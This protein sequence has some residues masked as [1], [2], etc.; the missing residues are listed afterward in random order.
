MMYAPEDALNPAVPVPNAQHNDIWYYRLAALDTSVVWRYRTTADALFT[1]TL[2]SLGFGQ[3]G[4][5]LFPS[6][7]DNNANPPWAWRGGSGESVAGHHW[8]SFAVDSYGSWWQ[9]GKDWPMIGYGQ[10]LLDPGAALAIRFTGLVGLDAPTVYNPYRNTPPPPP[11]PDP[12]SV[13]ID[14]P[15]ETRPTDDCTWTAVARGGYPPYTYRWF[16]DDF[17]Q[18]ETINTIHRQMSSG[19]HSVHVDVSDSH[20][21]IGASKGVSTFTGAPA[22]ML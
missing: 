20:S 18:P 5:S 16:V 12:L 13:T 8:Y 17:E 1:G 14:G 7:T 15:S 3:Q 4:L 9:S 21:A 19:G 10:L 2:L 22:C 6:S 11:P